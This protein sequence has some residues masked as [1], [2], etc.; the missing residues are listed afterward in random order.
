[1]NFINICTTL[2]SMY[3]AMYSVQNC[4]IDCK[5]DFL[6]FVRQNLYHGMV[7]RHKLQMTRTDIIELWDQNKDCI[8][9]AIFS[10][11]FIQTCLLTS[12]AFSTNSYTS[13]G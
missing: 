3:S 10:L 11:I 9:F 4:W 8:A 7:P 13:E 1:M 2:N 5:K 6:L 12:W